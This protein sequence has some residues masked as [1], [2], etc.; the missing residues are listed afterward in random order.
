VISVDFIVE[1]PESHG[2][3]AIM[4]IVDS[5]T[6]RAHFI[7]THTT[8]TAKGAARLYLW[9]VWK[10]H[11]TPR[12]VL[13]DRGSQF[14]AGFMRELYKLLEMKTCNVDGLPS[15]DRRLSGELPL[16]YLPFYSLLS[17]SL[18]IHYS[19]IP[20]TFT[21]SLSSDCDR[22]GHSHVM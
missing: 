16:T 5:V 4:N 21:G 20:S 9:D 6:K 19:L 2:Y 3:N 17:L 10:H 8:I 14:V 11:G 1:L 18:S 22:Y 15:S 7:P 13:S 12:V